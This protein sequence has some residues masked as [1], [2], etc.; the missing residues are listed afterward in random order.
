M[1]QQERNPDHWLLL[2]QGLI[3]VATACLCVC[4]FGIIC[5]RIPTYKYTQQHFIIGALMLSDAFFYVPS[6][7]FQFVLFRDPGSNIGCEV[8]NFTAATWIHTC[9]L[10]PT[11]FHQLDLR[12]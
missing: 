5:F 7:F 4:A 3:S 2:V 10:V 12:P 8:C 11:F 6:I 9:F 1:S